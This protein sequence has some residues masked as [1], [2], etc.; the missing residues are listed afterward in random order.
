M[1]AVHGTDVHVQMARRKKGARSCRLGGEG[2]GAEFHDYGKRL[3]GV[4]L[5]LSRDRDLRPK[6]LMTRLVRRSLDSEV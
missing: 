1:A 4:E 5:P 2:S 6:G 3:V